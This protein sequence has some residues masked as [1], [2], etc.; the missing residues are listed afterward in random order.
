MN[1]IYA[2]ALAS[3]ALGGCGPTVEC[4]SDVTAGTGTFHGSASG[5]AQNAELE[6][7]SLRK[8]CQNFCTKAAAETADRDGC[9]SRCMADVA[10]KKIG[11][12]TSCGEVK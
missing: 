11:A 8:A 5:K 3:L 1:A 10:A 2:I 4:A 9:T 6:Q 12:R 7:A